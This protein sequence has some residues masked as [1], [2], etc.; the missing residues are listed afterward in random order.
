MKC[1]FCASEAY[2]DSWSNQWFVRCN[3]GKCGAIGP[4]GKTQK[5]AESRWNAA[6]VG[7]NRKSLTL[8]KTSISAAQGA[9]PAA[10]RL[11]KATMLRM[12]GIK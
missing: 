12:S 8:A 7:V 1:V 3:D 2:S 6:F 4:W 9:G 10:E 11:A 5:E